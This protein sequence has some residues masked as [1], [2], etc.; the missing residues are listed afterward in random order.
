MIG[1]HDANLDRSTLRGGGHRHPEREDERSTHET[2]DTHH[3]SLR[4]GDLI[5][6]SPWLHLKIE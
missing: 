3:G 4:T 6:P 2:N 5:S 1:I